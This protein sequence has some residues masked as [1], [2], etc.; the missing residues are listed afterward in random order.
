M[1]AYRGPD[2]YV[3]MY[4]TNLC[5]CVCVYVGFSCIYVCGNFP[6]YQFFMYI[7]SQ[8]LGFWA[9]HFSSKFLL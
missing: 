7:E 3:C 8:I 5:M 6:V 1:Y 2:I 4:T 9:R